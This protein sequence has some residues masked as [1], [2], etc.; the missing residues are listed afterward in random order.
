[1]M[2]LGAGEPCF[3]PEFTFMMHLGAGEP[4]FAPEFAFVMHLGQE[5]LVS[6]RNISCFVITAAEKQPAVLRNTLLLAREQQIM[7]CRATN[8]PSVAWD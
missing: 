4:C 2:H 8:C 3:A 1:M 7:L 6:P 5:S